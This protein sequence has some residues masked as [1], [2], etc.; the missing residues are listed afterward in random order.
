MKL[1]SHG[2]EPCASANSAISAKSHN[3]SILS[4][5]NIKSKYFFYSFK[6]GASQWLW[7]RQEPAIDRIRIEVGLI[8]RSFAVSKS[9]KDG[10]GIFHKRRGVIILGKPGIRLS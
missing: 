10:L 6:T 9:G 5:I 7:S 3:K 1:L 4:R 8:E 2:P